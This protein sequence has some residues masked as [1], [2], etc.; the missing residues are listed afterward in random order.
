MHS[1]G[2][3]GTLGAREGRTF[4][5]LLDFPQQFGLI[6]TGKPAYQYSADIKFSASF[7]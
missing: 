4:R 2:T 5:Q 6:P 3:R 7:V 1:K